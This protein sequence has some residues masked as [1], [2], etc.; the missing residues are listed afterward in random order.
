MKGKI[1]ALATSGKY[2]VFNK[3]AALRSVE[4]FGSG[5]LGF[6]KVFPPSSLFPL[7]LFPH[8]LFFFSGLLGTSR[9]CLIC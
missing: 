1:R 6:L 5:D 8:F 4:L 7:A 3:K 2:L 9:N